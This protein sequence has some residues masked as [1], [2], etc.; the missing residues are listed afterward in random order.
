MRDN[1][2]Y[3]ILLNVTL[4]FGLNAVM[5]NNCTGVRSNETGVCEDVCDVYAIDDVDGTNDSVWPMCVIFEIK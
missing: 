3:F 2:A 5:V 1:F 4:L